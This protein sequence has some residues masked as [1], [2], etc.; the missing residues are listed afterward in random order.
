MSA[1]IL[2]LRTLVPWD[3]NAVLR[4]VKRTHRCL[5]V[6]EDSMTAGFGA[7]VAAVVSKQAFFSLDAPVERITTPDIPLPYN[8][9][10]METVL[11]GVGMI[12]RQIQ[13]T[14]AV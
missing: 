11:P 12:A 4:S 10:L 8:N 5:V 14:L 7:E 2:D 3:E 9:A 1:D 13:R 6:H